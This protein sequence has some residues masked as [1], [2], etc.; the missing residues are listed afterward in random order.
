MPININYLQLKN[1]EN[2][3]VGEIEFFDSYKPA[4]S[5][6]PYFYLNQKSTVLNYQNWPLLV[7]YLY[8]QKIC[9]IDINKTINHC[10]TVYSFSNSNGVATLNFTSESALKVL[11]ALIEDRKS[12]YLDNNNSYADWNKTITPKIDITVN[13]IVFFAIGINYYI[14][15]VVVENNTGYI[16]VSSGNA[17]VINNA[18]LTNIKIDFGLYR[19]PGKSRTEEVYY[20][21][22]KGK[23]LSNTNPD[24]FLSGL[25]VRSQIIGH[26]HNHNHSLNNH[27][28]IMQHT[29]G[30]NNH[31]HYMAHSHEYVDFKSNMNQIFVGDMYTKV[32]T[33]GLSLFD[34]YRQTSQSKEFTDGPNINLTSLNVNNTTNSISTNVT[35]DVSVKT[36]DDDNGIFS[37]ANN[38]KINNKNIPESYTVYPYIYGVKYVAS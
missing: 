12:Y 37:N 36:T 25:R 19:I 34:Q 31:T 10:F 15:N 38:L 22:T 4:S 3:Q 28:H 16:T 6:F 33:G 9:V 11:K 13:G 23:F 35:L 18:I 8:D 32:V 26:T 30:L 29:H 20:S 27:T 7:P 14:N 21:M 1:Q 17:T 5:V 2:V 24:T